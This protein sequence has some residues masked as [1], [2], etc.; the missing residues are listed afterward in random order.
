MSIQTYCPKC[1]SVCGFSDNLAGRRAKCVNCGQLFIVP[2]ED[3]GIAVKYDLPIEKGDPLPGF[4]EAVFK[5][6]FQ[7]IFASSSIG[8]LIF[9]M[10]LTCLWYLTGWMNFTLNFPCTS[11]GF[12]SVYL[13]LGH[14]MTFIC[15]GLIIHV[16]L[17]FAYKTSIDIEHISTTVFL[18]FVAEEIQEIFM[19]PYKIC[20]YAAKAWYPVLCGLLVVSLPSIISIGIM[21]LLNCDIPAVRWSLFAAGLIFWPAIFFNIARTQ[22][23]ISA[24]R[25]NQVW[26]IIID[27]WPHYLFLAAV[28]LIP[29]I[30]MFLMPNIVKVFRI[31]PLLVPAALGAVCILQLLLL[32]AMRTTG[33]FDRHFRDCYG[34]RE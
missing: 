34:F 22:D 8:A 12:V 25:L 4:Y 2:A 20:W 19:I 6:F 9:I 32:F 1:K 3:D 11:G 5:K 30:G 14:F 15:W 31:H 18:A 26:H 33:L 23:F 29:A 24:A 10:F 7:A 27:T 13:P 21:E 17:D 16:F 28:F